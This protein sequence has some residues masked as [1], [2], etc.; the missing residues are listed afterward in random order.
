MSLAKVVVESQGERTVRMRFGFSDKV[1]V[2]LNGSLLYVGEDSYQSRDF[3][4]LGTVGLYDS[5]FLHLRS[6]A[7][8]VLFIV[9]E[10]F[11][12]GAVMAVFDGMEGLN[13]DAP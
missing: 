9:N 12:G 11:G 5:L 10:A 4:F 1:A 2:F 7:N 8:E 3:A 13:I 6:G